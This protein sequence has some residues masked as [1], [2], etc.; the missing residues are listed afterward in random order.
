MYRVVVV[1]DEPFMLEGMRLMIDWAGCGF[2][3]SGTAG[4]AQEA[5]RLVETVRPHLLITDVKM[6]GMMGTDLAAIMRYYHPDTEL[7]FFSGYQDFAF[8]Q[9]A[10]RSHAA[11][12]LLKPIDPDEVHAALGKVK[13]ELDRRQQSE[14]LEQTQL[15]ILRNHVLRRIA[16]GDT[17][18]DNL[19]RAGVLLHLRRDDPCYCAV[20]TC[21]QR[22]LPES[23]AYLLAAEGA[24]PFF[25]RPN[26]CG[27][28]FRQIERSFPL[29]AQLRV[30]LKESLDLPCEVA[31]GRV[32]RGAEGFALSL[33]QALDAQGVLF[34]PTQGLR[35]YH[36]IEADTAQ[37]LLR[38]D[39]AG[40]PA[41]LASE[42]PSELGGWLERLRTA[43]VAVNPS[44]F[45]CRY[46]ACSADAL[47]QLHAA[48][49]GQPK[50]DPTPLRALW[51][52]ETVSREKWLEEFDT[53]LRLL[54]TQSHVQRNSGFPA[55]VQSA[56]EIIRTRYASALSIGELAGELHLNPAYLGQLMRKHTGETFHRLLL[57][58]RISHACKALRRT[59]QTVG[60]IA[61][62]VGFRDVDYFSQQFRARMGMSPNAYRSQEGVAHANED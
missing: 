32:G 6:P 14:P 59:N 48:R 4:S 21:Q 51:L 40:L 19:I 11:G 50:G 25:L 45:A 41:A 56:L 28:C 26:M 22:Q 7:L 55:P 3:L 2:T 58:E 16:A 52:E 39:C 31:V 60:E 57:D 20:V 15:S 13:A 1:D 43:M 8:A 61:Y 54:Y 9:S 35:V 27:L 37:W 49:L 5:L 34:E 17:S 24:A 12:Y 36:A 23:A 30:R 62:D 46:L 29:L 47:L 44:L 10:I 33:Q 53:R 38:A 18:T 42:D